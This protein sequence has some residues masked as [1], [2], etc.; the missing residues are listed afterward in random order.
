MGFKGPFIGVRVRPRGVRQ[1]TGAFTG[2][3]QEKVTGKVGLSVRYPNQERT[4]SGEHHESGK[5]NRYI[6]R[7]WS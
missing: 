7:S 3:D 6:V 2:H 4:D 5:Y 1:P